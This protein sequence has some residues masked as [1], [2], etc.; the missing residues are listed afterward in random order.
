MVERAD[1]S[2]EGVE[3]QLGT[4]LSALHLILL[5]VALHCQNVAKVRGSLGVAVGAVALQV[6]THA[7]KP[8]LG[9]YGVVHGM[10]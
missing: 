1:L 6:T 4:T 3:L 2:L 5:P 10:C 7:S 9:S 8:A